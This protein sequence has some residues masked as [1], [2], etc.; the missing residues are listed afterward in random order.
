MTRQEPHNCD[1]C[2]DMFYVPQD[3]LRTLKTTESEEVDL[4]YDLCFDC[5]DKLKKWI[6]LVRNT[7]EKEG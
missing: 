2:G 6:K 5:Y 7:K 4:D 1:V 3:Q